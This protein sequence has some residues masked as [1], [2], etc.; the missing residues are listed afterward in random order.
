MNGLMKVLRKKG[1]LAGLGNES[2]KPIWSQS[3]VTATAPEVWD[4]KPRL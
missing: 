3:T 4:P 1:S 2:L